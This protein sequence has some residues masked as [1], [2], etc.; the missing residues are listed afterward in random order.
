MS[1]LLAGVILDL[2]KVLTKM[3]KQEQEGAEP[4]I[5]SGQRERERKQGSWW[6]EGGDRGR[7]EW[8]LGGRCSASCCRRYLGC[9]WGVPHVVT[10][11][12]YSSGK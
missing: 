10:A 9:T 1:I 12:V 4:I 7:S 3:K 8:S 6:G 11:G 2:K 5:F